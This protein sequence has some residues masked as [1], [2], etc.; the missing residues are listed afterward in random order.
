MAK[1]LGAFVFCGSASIGVMNNGETPTQILELTDDM[2]KDN[3]MHFAHNHPEIPIIPPTVWETDEYLEKLRGEE[4]DLLYG[5]PP[6][7]G[8]SLG[9]RG[10]QSHEKGPNC[11]QYRYLN[12]IEKTQPKAFMYENA[13]TLITTGKPILNDFVRTL[14]NYNFTVIREF[15]MYHGVAMKRQRTFFIG[16]RKDAFPV[17]PTLH[18][19]KSTVPT[20][21]RE[22]I[23]D[24]FEV[25]VGEGPQAHELITNRPYQDVEHIFGDVPYVEG[26]HRT[27]NWVICNDWK[28][29]EPLLTEK[30]KKALAT[31]LYKQNADLGYWDK[32]SQRPNPDKQAPSMTGYSS[33]IHPIHNRQFTIR[34]YAR[35]MGFPDTFELLP[36]KDIVRHLAQGVPAK[37]FQWASGE[38]LAA[39]RGERGSQTK[40]E[41]TRVVFQHHTKETATEFTTDEFLTALK[42]ADVKEKKWNLEI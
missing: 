25:P 35:L 34:E 4:Y 9:V 38:V 33:F 42:I 11:H 20:T 22:I 2:H 6:C 39:L 17:I 40:Y 1:I 14:T 31:Q 13:P 36:H 19:G 21:V 32:S 3:A 37:Y 7:S 16:W 18:M 26:G 23:G 24:L 5:N 15:G 12:I 29:Y 8:L 10:P 28:K 30:T 41:D 27:V